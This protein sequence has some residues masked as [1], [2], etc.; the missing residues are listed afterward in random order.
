[1]SVIGAMAWDRGAGQ[2]WA[3]GGFGDDTT[4]YTIDLISSTAQTAFTGGPG[5]PDGLAYDGTDSTLWLSPDVSPTVYHY[6]TDG[7]L[8]DQFNVSLGNCGN[9]GIAIGGPYLF[10]SNDGCSQIYRSTPSSPGDVTLFGSYSARLEDMEC[11]DVTFAADGK[12]AIWSKDAYDG[13]LNAFELNPGDCGFGGLPTMHDTDGDGLPDNWETYGIWAGDIRLAN[14]P[15]LGARPDHKDIF[16]R[17][18]GEAGGFLSSAAQNK[19]ISS[20]AIAPVTNPDGHNGIAVHFLHGDTVSAAESDALR[21]SDG[22]A[23]YQKIFEHWTAGSFWE[24]Y[25]AHYV[26]SVHWSGLDFTGQSASIPSQVLLLNFCD[27]RDLTRYLTCKK[28]S[29]D[30]QATTLMHELGHNLGLHHGGND[31]MNFKPNYLSIMNYSFADPDRAGIPGIGITYSRWGTDSLNLLDEASIAEKDGVIV[32]DGSSVPSGAKTV[33]YCPKNGATK[34]VPVGQPIDWNCDQKIADTRE[35]ANINYPAPW[36]KG[37]GIP[38]LAALSRLTPY[39]DWA[40]LVFA[41]GN[42]GHSTL[43]WAAGT[44]IA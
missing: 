1:M 14:L 5:C 20:F 19:V 26:L 33:Y 31:D 15:S 16:L 34:V 9:S 30:F 29:D 12:A 10:L 13:V 35:S 18:D 21:T 38:D 36:R 17:I 40:H 25:F 6:R 3:C 43:N 44:P 41:G 28:P 7:T 24:A 27:R 39:D 32:K 2:L 23:D 11:D 4:V 8:I 22:S 37:G 42:I